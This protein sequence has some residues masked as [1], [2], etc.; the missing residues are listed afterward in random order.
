VEQILALIDNHE[1]PTLNLQATAPVTPASNN[2]EVRQT[3]ASIWAEM[4]PF[5]EQVDENVAWRDTGADSLLTLQFLVRLEQTLKRPLSFD[6]FTLDMT[7]GEIIQAIEKSQAYSDGPAPTKPAS[8]D[9]TTLFLIPGILGDEPVLAEFRHSLAGQVHFE[10]LGE[11]DIDQPASVLSSMTATAETLVKRINQIQPEGPLYLSGYSL[12]GMLAFQAANDLT[13]AGRD[14]RLVCILDAMYGRPK[15]G[16]VNAPAEGMEGAAR[17]SLAS[18]FKPRHKESF[19]AYFDR[20]VYGM[21]I[22]FN[23]WEAARQWVISAARRNDFATNNTRRIFLLPRF[24][25]EAIM[26]WRPTPSAVPALLIV[27]DEFERKASTD[28]WTELCPNLTIQRVPGE[29][30]KIF[31]PEALAKL[32]PAL[33][34]AL[35]RSV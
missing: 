20:L 16:A 30:E 26:N 24:R 13:A 22:R 17:A 29:H 2:S 12:G 21:L 1:S 10:T 3:I 6:M 25:G 4:M 34:R 35:G 7:V 9:K 32:N 11:I 15:Q 19:V 28:T 18:R 33:L 23:R 8:A 14:V 31:E 27:S 5:A